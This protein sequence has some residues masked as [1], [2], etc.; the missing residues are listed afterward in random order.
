MSLVC[1]YDSSDTYL[2]RVRDVQAQVT[3]ELKEHIRIELLCLTS[4][5]LFIRKLRHVL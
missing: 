3:A 5:P 4:Q 1:I 2:F